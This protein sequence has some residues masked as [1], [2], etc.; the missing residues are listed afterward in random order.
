MEKQNELFGEFRDV[1]GDIWKPKAPG[2]SITGILIGK[3]LPIGELSSRFYLDLGE[4]GE[5]L[6]KKGRKLVWGTAVLDQRMALVDVG[7]LV[8][9]TWKGKEKCKK[10]T[11]EVHIWKVEEAKRKES[12]FTKEIA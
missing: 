9:I 3:I 7:S 5:D 11:R 2:D 8:K 6:G 10:G 4:K 12:D 1:E